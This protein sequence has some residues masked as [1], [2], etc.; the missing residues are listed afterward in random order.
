MDRLNPDEADPLETFEQP[1]S[2]PSV[3]PLVVTVGLPVGYT[4]TVTQ[5]G[6][7]APGT[8]SLPGRTTAIF[9][10]P[11]YEIT[12]ELGR[13]G[14]GVVYQARQSSLKRLVALKMIRDAGA[15]F[16]MAAGDAPAGSSLRTLAEAALKTPK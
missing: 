7:Q 9:A 11:G 13:G 14:M 1:K 10:P 12:G 15:A 2:A 4:E 6:T 3:P 8:V 16:K 5:A